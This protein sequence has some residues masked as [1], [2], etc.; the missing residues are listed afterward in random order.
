MDVNFPRNICI[1][2]LLAGIH[3]KKELPVL[4]EVFDPLQLVLDLLDLHLQLG[5]SRD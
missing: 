1:S 3:L 2:F 4:D 5:E